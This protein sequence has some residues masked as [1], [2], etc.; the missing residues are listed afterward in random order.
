MSAI[1]PQFE[2]LLGADRVVA[3]DALDDRVQRQ[4]TQALV[5]NANIG[6]VVYPHTQAE[7]AEAMT[8]AYR[9][10][11]AV[12]PC[13]AGS[14]LH[15]GGLASDVVVVVSTARLNRCLDH[16]VGDF[17]VTVE[18]GMS[19]S[20]LQAQLAQSR[21]MVAIAP[22]YA[23]QAT[24]GGVVATGDTGSL[25]HRYGGVRDH[26]IGLS[27]VRYDGQVAKAGGR[28]VKNVAGYDLMK[29]MIGSWG[30]LGILSQLTFRLY[31]LPE[32]S[33]SVRLSGTPEA[34]AQLVQSLLISRLTP[35][36]VDILAGERLKS[37]V[38]DAATGVVAR[39]QSIPASM[40]QQVTQLL[41]MATQCGLR[42]D[43][44]SGDDETTLWQQLQEQWESNTIP[45]PITCK[46]GV[47]PSHSALVLDKIGAIAPLSSGVMRAGSGLGILRWSGENS[48]PS[49]I[50][51]LRDLCQT[52]GG[53][54]TVLEAPHSWKNSLDLWGYPGNALSLM[55]AIKQQFDPVGLLS[56]QRFLKGL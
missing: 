41:D 51:T 40:E 6:A 19:V 32:Q 5:L 34:I 45:D 8:C 1:A 4:V 2:Q 20:A 25:R 10:R 39:F 22:T 16:A 26:L 35:T 56:P 23:D 24:W 54:L 42:G 29:L 27:L 31:P 50:R 11:W 15:W 18:A 30:T 53:F 7:L 55:Q 17:T 9:N 46:I 52:H 48:S 37:V 36:A 47:L 21:Q 38:P 44:L 33:E 13:G 43:R 14:K 49:V 3:W 28:V 12:L